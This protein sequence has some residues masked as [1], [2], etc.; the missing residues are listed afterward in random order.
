M[1]KLKRYSILT[2]FFRKRSLESSAAA[3]FL[4]LLEAVPAVHRPAL[5]GLERHFARL[6]AIRARCVI[7]WSIC[8]HLLTS[9]Y[10]IRTHYSCVRL[11][12]SQH[13]IYVKAYI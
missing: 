10:F 2:L 8:V 13:F 11:T 3:G 7:H 1:K 5:S 9:I 12:F 6:T 4:V